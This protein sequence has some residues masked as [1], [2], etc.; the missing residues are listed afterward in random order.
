MAAFW[1][2]SGKPESAWLGKDGKLHYYENP[3]LGK[4]AHEDISA[5][6]FRQA[7]SVDRL[8][9]TNAMREEVAGI[10]R[11]HMFQDHQ[12]PTALRARKFRSKHGDTLV[13]LLIA[14]KRADIRGKEED[15]DEKMRG[16]IKKLTEFEDILDQERD[17][18]V[19]VKDLAI[20]GSDLIRLGYTPGPEIG[21][22][23]QAMLSQVIGV[24]GNNNREWL[25]RAARQMLKDG[26]PVRAPEQPSGT[27]A[28]RAEFMEMYPEQMDMRAARKNTVEYLRMVQT[29]RERGRRRPG[30][31]SGP[32]DVVLTH[33]KFFRK[34]ASAPPRD[35]PPEVS[36]PGRC[37]SNALLSVMHGEWGDA[38]WAEGLTYVEGWAHPT[39]MIPIHHAWLVDSEGNVYDSTWDHIEEAVYLG[40]PFSADAVK[41][42][43]ERRGTDAMFDH[44]FPYETPIPEAWLVDIPGM[45]A[46]QWMAR[47][48]D[49]LQDFEKNRTLEMVG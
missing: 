1:H 43:A 32:E 21:G 48:A 38:E 6:L 12:K 49:E 15:S 22:A 33:G 9:Y 45:P 40:V 19:F 24:P 23:L 27:E 28:N 31:Y 42:E 13:P 44:H 2:D 3:E 20:N 47:H 26:V 17:A 41:D 36:I 16:E 29:V 25:E 30:A 18:P 4:R 5:D 7:A 8:A 37:F 34:K 10:I 11:S 35:F 46:S 39:G 14:H